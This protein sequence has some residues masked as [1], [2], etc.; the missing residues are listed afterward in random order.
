MTQGPT[1]SGVEITSFEFTL[2]DLGGDHN[3]FNMV[4]EPG[5]RL[6]QRGHLL[7]I[8][9]DQ[10][11]SGQFPISGPAMAQVLMCADYLI[12]RDATA[13]EQVYNDLK[14]AL[15]H[16]DKLGVGAIDI[17]LWDIAGKLYGEPLYRLLGGSR[18]PL[19]AYAST[20][21]GDENGGLSEPR[22]FAEFAVRCGE[23]GYPAFKIHGWGIAARRLQR[24]I[25]NV[26][27]VRAAVGP[28]MALMLD[29][30]CEIDTFGQALAV[31]RACDEADF[32]WYEDPFKDGGVSAFAH[33]KLRQLLKTPILQTEHVRLL[34]QHVDFI[35]PRGPTTSGP[36][37]T[38][39]AG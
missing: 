25:E 31:G 6:A 18:R 3:G 7:Q 8:H 34:E 2:Q 37:P 33:R 29:P 17:C 1:I 22:Q 12:G 32:F 4:Y 15:R 19:P 14:R 20:L 39:T 27:A 5:G 16:Y 23:M 26:L 30:A 36:A 9:T 21:H 24:E 38:R 35:W 13:R 10:G 28:Q 11:V